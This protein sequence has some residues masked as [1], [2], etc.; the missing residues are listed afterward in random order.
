LR[1]ALSDKEN[2]LDVSADGVMT[3]SPQ[4][5]NPDVSLGNALKLME[6]RDSPISVLPVACP[7]SN[8]LLG[9]IRLHDIYTPSS[10]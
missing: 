10:N 9:M 5:I 6:D 3:I 1:R 8:K 4:S 2:L 7:K